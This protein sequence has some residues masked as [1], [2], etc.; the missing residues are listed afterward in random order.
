M[1]M[2]FNRRTMDG[3]DD[4]TNQPAAYEQLRSYVYSLYS[5]PG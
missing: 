5:L 2:Y 3:Q 1:Y 4:N